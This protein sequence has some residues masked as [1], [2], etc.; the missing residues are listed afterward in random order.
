MNRKFLQLGGEMQNAL[1][2]KLVA[3][4]QSAIEPKV[5]ALELAI[6]KRLAQAAPVEAASK[7]AKPAKA[8]AKAA[9]K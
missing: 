9:S 5:K 2:D 1:I 3:E 7:A 4:T 8:P 6:G